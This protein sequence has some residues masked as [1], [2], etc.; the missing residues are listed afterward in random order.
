MTSI[1]LATGAGKAE[2]V[3]RITDDV[4]LADPQ[5]FGANF[6]IKSFAPWSELLH[7]CW[8]KQWSCE[9]IVFRHNGAATGGGEDYIEA[10]SGAPVSDKPFPTSPGSGF[11][12]TMGNGFW[13]GA[14]VRIYRPTESSVRLLRKSRVRQFNG[15]KD[16]DQR[17]TLTERGEPIRRGDLF[18]LTMTRLDVPDALNPERPANHIRQKYAELP[19]KNTEV[20]WTLDDSTF[21]PE[22]GSTASMK[23]SI[24]ASAGKDPIGIEQ[25]FLRFE[26]REL[27]FESGKTYRAEVWLK[28]QGIKGPVTIQVGDRVT[29][30]FE[31]GTEW[32]KFEFDVPNS[33]PIG[34]KTYPL[35]VGASTPGTLWLDN[36]LIAQTDVPPFGVFPQWLNILRDFRPGVLRSMS[37]RHLLTLDAWLSDRFTRNLVWDVNAGPQSRADFSLREQLELCRAT[38]A[39]PWLMTYVLP[40]DEEL[41]H[42]MEYLGAPADVGYGKRRA[43]DGQVQ[44]WTEVFDAIYIECANEMWNGKF[45]APQAFDM[46]AELAGLVANRVFERLKNSPYNQRGNIR[47]VGPAWAHNLYE[48]AKG[49]TYRAAMSCPA[50]DVLG[51]APSGYIGG[52]DGESIVGVHDADL[53]QANLFYSAQVMEPK[54]EGVDAIRAAFRERYGRNLEMLK[55]EAGPGYAIPNPDRPFIEAAEQVGKSL[56]MGIATLDNFLFVMAHD[57]NAN[58]FQVRAGPNWSSHNLQLDPHTTWLAL[59]LR[60]RWCNGRLLDVIPESVETVD[61]PRRKSVGLGNDG[62]PSDKLIEER[63]GVPLTQLYAFQDGNRYSFLALNRSFTESKTI[64]LKL[65]YTPD[66]AYRAFVLEHADPRTTNRNGPAV[67][68][69][70]EQRTGFRDGFRLVLKPASAVVLVNTAAV[71]EGVAP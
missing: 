4:R 67:R 47:A 7:N 28:Q 35:L 44:P 59:S 60:N 61:L 25:P 39:R 32:R 66:P 14:E 41:D 69:R 8:N 19:T 16:T 21:C 3:Y 30:T 54:Q 11:W 71:Q 64:A 62:S 52:Y 43:L 18:V 22:N 6:E 23:I 10:V 56:A 51:T 65:P 46:Q 31:V 57:G 36:L 13:N 42:L 12:S 38:G 70:E 9:P 53:F 15:L 17:I 24:P 37:G 34:P 55:Y 48:Q 20:T 33:G 63:K 58:Y 1:L 29:K 49:W 2:N 45:F 5:R 26:G 50:M 40:D 27:A 68:I